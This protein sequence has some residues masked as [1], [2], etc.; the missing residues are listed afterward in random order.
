[1]TRTTRRQFLQAAGAGALAAPLLVRPALAADSKLHVACNQ[2]CWI[3]MYQRE[4][5]NFNAD[6]DA[7]LAEVK[8]SGMDGLEAMLGDPAAADQMIPLLKKHGL[9]MR[10]F[11]TGPALHDAA[12][13]KAGIRQVVETAARA[14]EQIDVQICVV[15]PAPVREGE[16]TDAQLQTQAEA[17]TQLGAALLERGIK[18]AYHFHAPAWEKDGREFHHV[19]TRSDPKLVHLCFD[20]HWVYRGSGNNVERVYEVARLYGKRS[21]EL[22]LR[23]SKDGIWTETFTEGDID[24]AKVAAILKA[25]GVKPLLV[26]EQAVEK[27]TPAT[28]DAVESHRR[29]RAYVEKIFG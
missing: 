7:G 21:A 20:T 4:K 17:M 8:R 24:H 11:Y 28:M 26:L 2:F 1:M 19:M 14:K 15:N 18:L 5:K 29:S 3:N 16:K 6:L 23:Q 13:A 27:G 10:S 12:T 9:E 22:H 25:Q